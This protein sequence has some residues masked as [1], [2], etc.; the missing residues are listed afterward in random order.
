MIKRPLVALFI[1][2]ATIT[3][4]ADPAGTIFLIQR[5]LPQEGFYPA[6]ELE[7]SPGRI[8]E[9]GWEMDQKIKAAP[10]AVKEVNKYAATLPTAEGDIMREYAS[11]I[12]NN[13]PNEL[14]S[15][16]R[17][18]IND[19]N[20]T[21]QAA[22]KVSGKPKGNKDLRKRLDR[23]WEALAART[24]VDV[25]RMGKESEEANQFRQQL[26][27]LEGK[28]AGKDEPIHKKYA[29]PAN[30]EDNA[31]YSEL[32]SQAISLSSLSD[33]LRLPVVQN[34]ENQY[35]GAIFQQPNFYPLAWREM[36]AMALENSD[37]GEYVR[38]VI[39][40]NYSQ[41]PPGG[42]SG[43]WQIHRS[44]RLGEVDIPTASELSEEKAE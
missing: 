32:A 23:A 15:T 7:A 44:W 40:R 27:T 34:G 2:L 24:A 18:T 21:I 37:E 29:M 1:A 42:V 38:V 17:Q 16:L 10:F 22:F 39:L 35:E 4:W 36:E 8:A 30:D 14:D 28:W 3:A 19:W 31:A 12:F 9:W 41:P 26:A 5:M 25:G 6:L 11:W 43:Q 13:V 33:K 20:K